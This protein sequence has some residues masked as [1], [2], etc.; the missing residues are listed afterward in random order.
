MDIKIIG[1]AFV[2]ISFIYFIFIQAINTKNY[3]RKSLYLFI[4]GFVVVLLFISARII[5]INN[6]YPYP[7]GKFDINYYSFLII[8]IA[9]NIIIPTIYYIKGYKRKQKF[10]SNFKKTTPKPTVKE[11]RNFL[12][13]IIRNENDFLLNKK[14]I[15]EKD[16]YSGIIIKFPH[17]EFFHDEII[18]DFINQYEIDYSTYKCIGKVTKPGK[19]DEL[20]YCYKI[21]I[22]EKTNKISHLENINSFE[23]MN[24]NINDFDKT[25]LFISIIEDQS[26]IKL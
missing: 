22:N 8:S 11:K 9:Y 21:I 20:Y 26:D 10:K 6:K 3:I 17:S 25:I 16:F 2:I 23:L 13:I 1:A 19:V 15:E 5:D 18:R 14:T 7:Y 12:Y 24:K 4:A